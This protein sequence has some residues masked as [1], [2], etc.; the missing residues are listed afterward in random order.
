VLKVSLVKEGDQQLASEDKNLSLTSYIH[1]YFKADTDDQNIGSHT[2]MIQQAFQ[3][4]KKKQSKKYIKIII[5]VLM[6]AIVGAAYSIYK[7]IRE[8]EFKELAKNM[9]YTM[10]GY[11]IELNSLKTD[12]E[13]QK[14]IREKRRKAEEDYDKFIESL[15][16]YSDN[17]E[18]RLI[19]KIARKFGE[20]EINIPDNFVNE[21]KDYID[22]WKKS[23]R[24]G[25]SILRAKT[26]GY[27]PIIVGKFLENHLPH[28]FYYLALQESDF[29]YDAVGP[30]TRYGYAKGIWQFIV[31]TAEEY[32]LKVG[33]LKDKN[34]YDPADERF[35]FIKA[36]EAATNYLLHIYSTVA[37]ASG[38]LVV[39]SYNMGE[40][41][42]I[43]YI[44]KLTP[45][46]K[47]RNFWNLLTK[48]RDKIPDETYNYV[49]MI[50]S[51]AVIGE[52]PSLFGFD[53]D[54]PLKEITE[55]IY[56]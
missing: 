27:T 13:K 19:Q 14:K 44:K 24:L 32:G 16:L 30:I 48:Y 3:V 51:A 4:V 1:R 5:G 25:K 17:E 39:A 45:N 15:G 11:E 36:T 53:F 49:F 52:D 21:V 41:R 42:V 43:K 10:K 18:E 34:S 33:P 23:Q 46:P 35:D 50:F 47:E 8:N 6:I 22:E 37:Q 40:P 28:Q 9:F 12:N 20:C 7:H 55:E 29:K 2:R 38:L 31:P 56:Y 54:N 26:Q